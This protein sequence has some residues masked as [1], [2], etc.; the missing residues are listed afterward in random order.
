MP[1][2]AAASSRLPRRLVLVLPALA[3]VSLLTPQVTRAADS[4]PSGRA[5]I[6]DVIV[7]GDPTLGRAIRNLSA[8]FTAR[9][10]APVAV[11]SAPPA[12]MLAQLERE[13][14]NDVLLTL[15]GAMD[16]GE[17]E[18]LIRP[19][20]RIGRWR[21]SLAIAARTGGTAA[22]TAD[23]ARIAELLGGG[24][25][26]LSDRSDAA[27]IDGPAV[28]ERLGLRDALSTARVIGA[29]DTE[30]VAILVA[31][32]DARLGLVH[33][34]NI[35]ADPRLAVAAMVPD[36]AYEPIVYSAAASTV[37]RSP[38]TQ[39]FLDFLRTPAAQR[40]LKRDGLGSVT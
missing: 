27:T 14:Q 35:R 26:A 9:T 3:G 29:A 17:R 18:H 10:K 38:N 21:N 33:L 31:T 40:Q 2:A 7:Y 30:E 24:R 12:L 15:V 20:T 28:I 5:A 39:L 6:P 4:A 32:G 16:Q 34:T 1:A 19:G 23:P 25:F 37:S 11:F 36:F 8:L 22:G 13:A